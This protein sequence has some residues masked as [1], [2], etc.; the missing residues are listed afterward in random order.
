[1][2]DEID[3]QEKGRAD[4]QAFLTSP[5]YAGIERQISSMDAMR[6][7]MPPPPQ[8]MM[9]MQRPLPGRWAEWKKGWE[10]HGG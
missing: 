1:M 7:F 3:Y 4:R 2:P 9:Q 8:D 10:S 5:I 6:I